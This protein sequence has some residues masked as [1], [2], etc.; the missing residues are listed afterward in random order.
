[1]Q[2]FATVTASAREY[3]FLPTSVQEGATNHLLVDGPQQIKKPLQSVSEQAQHSFTPQKDSLIEN[4][5]V[6][7]PP[8]HRHPK[9]NEPFA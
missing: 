6:Q 9:F 1:M 7:H 2:E 8:Q 5:P 4:L 3:Q